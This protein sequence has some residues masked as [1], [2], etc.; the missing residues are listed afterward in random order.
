MVVVT[1]NTIDHHDGD[2]LRCRKWKALMVVVTYS[3]V[4]L[5]G[6]DDLRCQKWRALMAMVTYNT[7]DLH[8][9]DDLRC[10]KW[11]TLMVL[12]SF[13]KVM[14]NFD[15]DDKILLPKKNPTFSIYSS[16]IM[17]PK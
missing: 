17:N 6:S 15:V 16:K 11:R 3:I 2:D 4:D 13:M 9:S 14:M 5:H 12:M 7:T 1:Y 8:G 10:R